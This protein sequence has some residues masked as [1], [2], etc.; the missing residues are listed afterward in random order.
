MDLLLV[1]KV[2]VCSLADE[3]TSVAER[4][5]NGET[6]VFRRSVCSRN[7]EIYS[8][9][10][11]FH[12]RGGANAEVCSPLRYRDRKRLLPYGRDHPVD[13]CFTFSVRLSASRGWLLH[14]LGGDE[15]ERKKARRFAVC[16]G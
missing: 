4:G 2:T 12:C 11:G 14:L 10:M 8:A 6:V 1:G 16:L 9:F 15:G 5:M 13:G 7:L 3:Q